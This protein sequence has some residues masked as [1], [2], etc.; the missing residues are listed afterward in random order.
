MILQTFNNIRRIKTVVGFYI[1]E[2]RCHNPQA[3]EFKS[4]TN[5]AGSTESGDNDAY[6]H[7]DATSTWDKPQGIQSIRKEQACNAKY[8]GDPLDTTIS[9]ISSIEALNYFTSQ[10]P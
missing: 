4:L 3:R 2:S 1:S 6:D 10:S 9:A 5:A 7:D 8:I